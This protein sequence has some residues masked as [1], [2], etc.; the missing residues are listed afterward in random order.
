MKAEKLKEKRVVK[1]YKVPET[2]YKKVKIKVKKSKT[3]VANLIEDYLYDY[4][5]E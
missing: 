4:S 2:I 3:T 5:A 1:T